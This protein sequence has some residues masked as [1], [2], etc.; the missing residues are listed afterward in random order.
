M[1]KQVA[2]V[3]VV[4]NVNLY[5]ETKNHF[6]VTDMKIEYTLDDENNDITLINY[7]DEKN[8]LI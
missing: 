5:N 1:K 3:M 8:I 6:N 7:L 2:I 4:G